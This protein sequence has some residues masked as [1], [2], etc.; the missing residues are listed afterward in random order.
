MKE[1]KNTVC[2][3]HSADL[4]GICSGAIMKKFLPGAELIG[5]NYGKPFPWEKVQGKNV[6][7][8]DVSLK[9]PEFERLL[10]E[11]NAFIWIDH[12]KS[13]IEEM[14]GLEIL[15]VQYIGKA[16][17][18]LCWE[19]FAQG[20][21]MPHA[22]HLLGRYDVWDHSDKDTLPFQFGMRMAV[23]EGVDDPIWESLLS[24]KT[25]EYT[26]N[27]RNFTRLEVLEKGKTVLEY[28]KGENKKRASAQAFE[29]EL[30]GFKLLACN[31]SLTNSQLFDS[32]WDAEK[33]HMMCPFYINKRGQWRFSLYTTREDVDCSELAKKMGGGGHQKAAGFVLSALPFETPSDK[34][35]L[36]ATAEVWKGLINVEN[37]KQLEREK[38]FGDV[39][40][41][42]NEFANII[43]ETFGGE[44]VDGKTECHTGDHE[45]IWDI[46]SKLLNRT[47][48]EAESK[49]RALLPTISIHA[50]IKG[51]TAG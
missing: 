28:Q 40:L 48:K 39:H 25:D 32:V 44:V 1:V 16:A 20:S 35:A 10:E 3:Y 50:P 27:E 42:A 8:A 2:F 6:Y 5:Y 15:G 41:S 46:C 7:M 33:Y 21:P 13:A 31:V 36:E 26:L 43:Y 22:V 45:N 4:D 23:K 47:Y 11:S 24:T 14:E 12:H 18:E 29:T 30:H 49:K 19:Y 51:P 38:Q 9:R 17:C 34:K 37:N